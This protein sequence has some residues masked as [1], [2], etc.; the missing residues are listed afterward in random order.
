MMRH[1]GGSVMCRDR[2]GCGMYACGGKVNS[3]GCLVLLMVTFGGKTTCGSQEMV[4]GISCA[5]T[6]WKSFGTLSNRPIFGARTRI[7]LIAELCGALV[8][9][10]CDQGHGIRPDPCKKFDG[11]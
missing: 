5:S 3:Q 10:L 9:I 2:I 1:I 8:P 4:E 7:Q 6:R 11:T